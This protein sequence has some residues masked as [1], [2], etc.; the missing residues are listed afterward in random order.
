MVKK[1]SFY[2]P[3]RGD[4]VWLDFDPQAGTEQAGRRP[5]IVLSPQNFNIATGL[6]IFCP[7]TNQ[8]KGSSFEV[9]LRA[10]RD[11]QASF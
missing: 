3:D 11:L 8:G 9:P 4:L 7:I 6:A 2:Q 10:G 5:A 1:N